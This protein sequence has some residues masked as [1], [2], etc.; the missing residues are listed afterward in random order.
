MELKSVKEIQLFSALNSFNRTAYG[1]EMYIDMMMADGL[2]F[3]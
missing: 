2:P 1:I 3:F